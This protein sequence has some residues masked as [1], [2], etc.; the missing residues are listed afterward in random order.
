ML[1]NIEISRN[2]DHPHI[3]KLFNVHENDKSFYLVTE[4]I[5]GNSLDY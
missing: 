2:L 3:L 5:K 1:R 4:C